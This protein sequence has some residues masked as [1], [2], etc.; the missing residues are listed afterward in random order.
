VDVSKSIAPPAA[1]PAKL[2]V[3]NLVRALRGIDASSPR[4]AA[5]DAA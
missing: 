5:T 1:P 2:T 4:A 3:I